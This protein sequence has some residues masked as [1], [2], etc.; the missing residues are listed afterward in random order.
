MPDELSGP[1]AVVSTD[2]VFS[3]AVED[4]L[5][6]PAGSGQSAETP[7]PQ[8]DR[9]DP[10]FA[11]DDTRYRRPLV[12]RGLRWLGRWCWIILALYPGNGIYNFIG[13]IN[14][15]Q[16][17]AFHTAGQAFF[18]DRIVPVVLAQPLDA[19]TPVAAVA[20]LILIAHVSYGDHQRE[21]AEMERRAKR[22]QRIIEYDALA[23]HAAQA[24]EGAAIATAGAIG[25][26]AVLPVIER[27]GEVGQAVGE[28]AVQPLIE[29]ATPIARAVGEAAV[30]PLL[31]AVVA[32]K[33][34]ESES[35]APQGPPFDEALLS[36]PE[37]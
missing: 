23:Q 16:P 14:A 31:E 21:R 11:P 25:G 17:F 22:D 5:P 3:V 12:V 30:A 35:Q 27:A 18:L 28:A 10:L 9:S 29:A 4:I 37:H 8:L 26:A 19:I 7:L 34:G 36:A 6:V 2:T 13:D 1:P 32:L 24:A 20:A 33:S 15:R